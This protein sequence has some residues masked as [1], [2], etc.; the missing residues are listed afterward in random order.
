MLHGLSL[1][2]NNDDRAGQENNSLEFL[3]KIFAI[4]FA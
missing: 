4:A 2:A 3:L 1:S